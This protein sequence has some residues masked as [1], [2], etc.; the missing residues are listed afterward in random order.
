MSANRYPRE[1]AYQHFTP[2]SSAAVVETGECT[3][4]SILDHIPKIDTG[5]LHRHANV[6]RL[7]HMVNHKRTLTSLSLR[8]C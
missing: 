1:P 6:T 8:V 3:K 7:L 5:G 2:R 4:T